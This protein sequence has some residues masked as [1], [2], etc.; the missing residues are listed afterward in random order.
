MG[1][2]FESEFIEGGGF[3]GSVTE[4]GATQKRLRTTALEARWSQAKPNGNQSWTLKL[5]SFLNKTNLAGLVLML[6]FAHTLKD[7]SDQMPVCFLCV[8]SNKQTKIHGTIHTSRVGRV[9]Q[10]RTNLTGE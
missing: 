2:L 1:Y 4:G 6:F 9:R 5:I 10:A 3:G 7:L 8:F